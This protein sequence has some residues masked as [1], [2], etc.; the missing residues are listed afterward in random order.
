[1]GASSSSNSSSKSAPD[2]CPVPPEY[3]NPAV[4]NVYGERLNDPN[5]APSKNPLL[6]L[7][8]SE[9]IDPR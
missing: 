9:I 5:A 7:K 4:Y 6:A 2:G 1:M 8:S 3:R